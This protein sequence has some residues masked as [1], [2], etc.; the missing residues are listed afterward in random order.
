M[1]S[2][3]T[4]KKL[5]IFI[6]SPSDV[7]TERAKVETVAAALKPL[8]DFIGVALETLDWRKAVPDMGRPQQVIFDQLQPT[9]WDVFIGILWHRFGTPPGGADPQTQKEYL[10]IES[11]TAFP[12]P[13][14]SYS[15]AD[16]E[17]LILRDRLAI[18]S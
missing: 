10:F 9:S 16:K 18:D 1:P 14:K 8:A 7:A 11:K 17:N 12:M 5:R 3:S 13:E 4:L 2:Q 6:A 15:D